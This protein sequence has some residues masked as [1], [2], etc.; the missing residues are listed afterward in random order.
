LS[1]AVREVVRFFRRAGSL[2]STS[3]R[4]PDATTAD[5][6]GRDERRLKVVYLHYATGVAGDAAVG[7]EIGRVG[8]DGVEAAGGILGGNGVQQFEAVSVIEPQ[9]VAGIVEDEARR[10]SVGHPA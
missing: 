6:R 10:C 2:G 9:P 1:D 8:K 5:A 3:G 4:R 7:K